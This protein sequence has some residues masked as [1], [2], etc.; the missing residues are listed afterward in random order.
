MD[1]DDTRAVVSSVQA[2]PSA[3][4]RAVSL[5]VLEEAPLFDLEAASACNIVCSFCPR[6][7]MARPERLMSPETFARVLAFLPDGA[8]VMFSGLGDALLNPRLEGFVAALTARAIASCVITNGLR[9]TP[10]RARALIDAG[11]R[12]FQVSVHGLD[13]G[14]LAPIVTRGADPGRVARHLDALAGLRPP[15]V[16][17]RVNFVET[18][19]NVASRELVRAW[20]EARGFRFF[21]RRLHTRGGTL[22][23]RRPAEAVEGCGIFAAV[24]FVTVEGDILPCVNDVRSEGVL[25]NVADTTFERLRARKREV[26]EGG[27][28]FAPCAGCNDD[29]R[30]IILANGAVD[31]RR[32]TAPPAR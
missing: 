1:D 13:A 17:V 10:Q 2:W 4:R 8:V 29:Y 3:R 15:D 7:E 22:T 26:I 31:E 23:R 16:R 5:R 18:P 20:A 9:L 6:D 24:T 27:S 30:W 21:F 11:L 12:E 25:G 14:S 32:S 19:E 28:W